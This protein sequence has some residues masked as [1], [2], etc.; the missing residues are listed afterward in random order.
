MSVTLHL[1]DCLEYMRTMSAGSVDAVVTDP[2]Y[3]IGYASNH[4]TR[5]G[6]APRRNGATFGKDEFDPRWIPEVYRV[7]RDNSYVYCFTRWDV[8]SMWR[9]AFEGAGFHV[10][11]RLVWDKCHW[12]MGDLRHYGSQTEDILL[13]TKGSPAMFEGGAG[14][15]G[16]L[17]RYS[18]FF[19]AEGQEDHPTQKPERLIARFILDGSKPGDTV[20]D[21]FFGSGP[22]PVACVRTGRNFIGCEIDP[23]YYAIAQRRIA[24]AQLQPPLFPHQPAGPAPEQLRIDL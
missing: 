18:K 12:G 19:L 8:L 2:P 16:D 9:D 15:R 23:A 17:F 4:K 1:G 24:E 13:M 10:A 22:T 6:G 20:L 7:L 5:L 11:Q 3:G 14:R 21:P